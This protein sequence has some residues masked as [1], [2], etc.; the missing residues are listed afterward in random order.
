MLRAT[1]SLLVL[2]IDTS[3]SARA[4]S[5]ATRHQLATLWSRFRIA[6]FVLEG[7]DTR[8]ICYDETQTRR[9][10]VSTNI[11]IRSVDV[12]FGRSAR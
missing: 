4:H 6:A 8:R 12:Q 5:L 1:R 10:V 11:I 9:L 2:I 7:P 3:R